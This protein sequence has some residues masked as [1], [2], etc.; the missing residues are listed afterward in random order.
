MRTTMALLLALTMAG[1]ATALSQPDPAEHH[2]PPPQ[3]GHGEFMEKLGLNE[4]QKTD[5]AGLRTDMEKS[6]V[7]IQAKIKIARID[8]K[9]MVAAESPDKASIEGKMKEI[10]DLQYQAKKMTV[11]HLFAVYALL[12]PEQQKM[13]KGQLMKRLSDGGMRPMGH[14]WGRDRG[15][16]PE[17]PG[18]H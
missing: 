1:G 11:D 14:R 16:M 15:G 9:N 10:S 6:L 3:R 2:G 4:K 18:P 5:I 13:F 12:T 17:E 8:M 7:G